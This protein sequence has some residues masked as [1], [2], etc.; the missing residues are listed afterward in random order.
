MKEAWEAV[1]GWYRAV[2]KRAPPPDRRSL[3]CQT[4]ERVDL[5]AKQS[6]PGESIPVHIRFGVQDRVPPE[7][8][9]R[10]AVR[11]RLRN[12]RSGGASLMR[13]EDVKRWLRG[14]EKEDEDPVAHKG[15]GIK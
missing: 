11:E 5:Y 15:A 9:I 10:G 1:K 7:P 6:P 3:K 4:D 8:E 2:N 13:A 14:R 12:G